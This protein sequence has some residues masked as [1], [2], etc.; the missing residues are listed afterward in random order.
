MKEY[1]VIEQDEKNKT[2]S[3]VLAFPIP[4]YE[5]LYYLMHPL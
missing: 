5:P 2:A 4:R 1:D 3:P